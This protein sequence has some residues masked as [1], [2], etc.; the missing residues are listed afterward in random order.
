M[1]VMLGPCR[2]WKP[3]WPTAALF[4]D[5]KR[6]W[7]PLAWPKG[8]SRVPPTHFRRTVWTALGRKTHSPALPHGIPPRSRPLR[9]LAVAQEHGFPEAHWSGCGSFA[10]VLRAAGSG[11]G[12]GT[13]WLLPH[14]LESETEQN[15]LPG[16]SSG[17]EAACSVL[18]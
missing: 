1:I 10:H 7:A 11:R 18:S 4:P 16:P 15:P 9:T 2:R 8:L 6:T 13:P 12:L 14:L 5:P 3:L 17:S